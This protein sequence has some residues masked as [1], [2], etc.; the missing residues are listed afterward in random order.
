MNPAAIALPDE[1]GKLN[2]PLLLHL[3]YEFEQAAVVGFVASD[4]VGSTTQH[5]VAV[6][7]PTDE[8]V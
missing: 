2:L 4:K 1:L 7:H 3:L 5:V 6:L 8:R